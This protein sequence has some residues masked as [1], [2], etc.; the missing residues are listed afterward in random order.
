MSVIGEKITDFTGTI[1]S[2]T[3]QDGSTLVNFEE[4]TFGT[5][6]GTAIFRPG[7]GDA[8]E[9]GPFTVRATLFMSDGG[10]QSV[11][12]EGTWRKVGSQQWEEKAILV[13]DDH[14]RL[15]VVDVFDFGTHSTKGTV[16][17]LD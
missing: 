12:G 1:T 8:A 9:A 3:M 4:D 13:G 7:A 17:A 2:V 6:L 5:V 14:Q 11:K 16:Y 15:Y 10:V